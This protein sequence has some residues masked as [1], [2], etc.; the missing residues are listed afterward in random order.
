MKVG[1]TGATGFLG[2][3]IIVEGKKRGWTVVAFSRG[4]KSVDGADETRSLA[5]PGS[6]DL[7]GLDAL[8]HLA[9]EPIVGLWTKDKKRR[10]HESRVDL[11][12][13]LVE[14]MNRITRTRRPSVFVSASA[15]GYYGDRADEWLDEESD[16]GFGFL[17]AVCR[18]WESASVGA[19]KL[20]VRLVNPR[21]GLVMGREGFLKR[22]RTVFKLGLGG[23]LGRGNQWM[24]WIHVE[25]LARIFAECVENAGIHGRVNCVSPRPATNREFT[26]V[27]ARVLGRPA[28]FT[29]PAFVLKRLPGGMGSVFLDSQRVE[30][31]V[32]QSFDFEWSFPDLESALRDVESKS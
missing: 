22:L 27:Y 21:I 16:V 9:G 18:D 14:A 5:D 11:T 26:T 31:V 8:I 17:P 10:I 24:S 4:E 32:M 2:S 13:D 20:G 25:D 19:E 12:R 15:I 29:V 23:R 6:I 28:L 7:D 30:P 3:A 1:I